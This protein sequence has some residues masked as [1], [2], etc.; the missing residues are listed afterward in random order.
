MM[1]EGHTQQL[2]QT[3]ERGQKEDAKLASLRRHVLVFIKILLLLTK[4]FRLM[5]IQM[6]M[7]LQGAG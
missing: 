1:R 2:G 4:N 3:R 6:D 7:S 5:A